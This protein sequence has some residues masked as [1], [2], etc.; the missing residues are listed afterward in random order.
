MPFRMMFRDPRLLRA[1]QVAEGWALAILLPILG[2]VVGYAWAYSKA[3]VQ[4]SDLN[5][6]HV[7]ELKGIATTNAKVENSTAILLGAINQKVDK[8]AESTSSTEKKADAAAVHAA[9][10]A[11]LAQQTATVV[12]QQRVPKTIVVEKPVVVPVPASSAASTEQRAHLRATIEQTNSRIK[13]Q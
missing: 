3:Q 6:T 7:N 4:I 13:G 12:K 5:T 9:S 11:D 1:L 2:G 8:V 10:A